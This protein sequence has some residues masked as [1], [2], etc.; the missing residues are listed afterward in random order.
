MV[1]MM[2]I[3]LLSAENNE[4]W[5]EEQGPAKIATR[6]RVAQIRVVR[7]NVLHWIKSSIIL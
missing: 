2:S 3:T 6:P 1:T 7:N 5:I 4:T